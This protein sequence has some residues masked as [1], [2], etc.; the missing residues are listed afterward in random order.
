MLQALK[1]MPVDAKIASF[2]YQIASNIFEFCQY[3][4]LH[5]Q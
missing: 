3:T 5:K 2:F 1:L 4:N